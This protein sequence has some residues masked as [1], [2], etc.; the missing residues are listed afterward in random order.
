L[1]IC[2]IWNK[3]Y[4]G[5]KYTYTTKASQKAICNDVLLLPVDKSKQPD[6]K[7]MEKLV[8]NKERDMLKKLIS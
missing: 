7:Y 6:W 1:F 8:K 5:K 3:I 4:A 2:S